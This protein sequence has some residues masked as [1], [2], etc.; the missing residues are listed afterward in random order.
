MRPASKR[1]GAQVVRIAP[2]AFLRAQPRLAR[3]DLGITTQQ[4]PFSGAQAAPRA[5]LLITQPIGKRDV[6]LVPHASEKK[7]AR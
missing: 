3:L 5:W 2:S 7:A 4:A 6:G 1:L